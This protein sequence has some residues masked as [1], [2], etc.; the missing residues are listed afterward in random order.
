MR[1]A[2]YRIYAVSLCALLCLLYSCTG[3]DNPDPYT[4]SLHDNSSNLNM[5]GEPLQKSS[6]D[7]LARI[8]ADL[9]YLGYDPGQADGTYGPKTRLAIKRFQKEHGLHTDGAAGSLTEQAILKAIHAR[10]TM[11][12]NTPEN[13]QPRQ[14]SNP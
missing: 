1:V 7:D 13:I 14:E 11:Q 5:K 10:K 8:Q 4:Q 12:K 2:A 3:T 9:Q 6:P